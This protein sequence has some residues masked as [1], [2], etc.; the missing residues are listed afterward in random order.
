MVVL[1]LPKTRQARYFAWGPLPGGAVP[2]LDGH[3]DVGGVVLSEKDV[4]EAVA[5]YLD[6]RGV[7]SEHLSGAAEVGWYRL[8]EGSVQRC[9]EKRDQRKQ[10]HNG[11]IDLSKRPVYISL[12]DYRLDPPAYP[13]AAST[14]RLVQQGSVIEKLCA[15]GN[16]KVTCA[17]CQGRGDLEC[18]ATT[19]CPSC[20]GIDACTACQGT[21]RRTGARRVKDT[22]PA[23][24]RVTCRAC[25]TPEAACAQCRG[26]G[27]ITCPTC[28]GTTRRECP[29]CEHAGT[30]P[31]ERCG[32]TG[33]TVTWTEGLI[34]RTPAAEQ[35][36]SQKTGL[37]YLARHYAR[38]AGNWREITLSH[39]DRIP[40]DLADD[41]TDLPAHL[42]TRIGE[43]ARRATVRH[44]TLA[45]VVSPLTPRRVYY[46]FPGYQAPVVRALPSTTWTWQITVA[47]LGALIVLIVLLTALA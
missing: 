11:P 7:P 14:I 19:A 28:Q 41:F 18:D 6:E 4:R 5:R 46:V 24:D 20:H 47:A 31:H 30:V 15:C 8:L 12:E 34:T 2:G 45:R 39:R 36:T 33:G 17:R 16:G 29:D 22:Q 3:D 1:P 9:I 10:V 43:I 21:G 27:R 37:P 32:G 35:F 13:F 40:A 42:N 44:L 25:G 23:D 38:Q 26:H